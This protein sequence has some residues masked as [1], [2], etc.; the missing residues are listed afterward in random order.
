MK[1]LQEARNQHATRYDGDGV[2]LDTMWH[3]VAVPLLE[4][5]HQRDLDCLGHS[6]SLGDAR[7]YLAGVLEAFAQELPPLYQEVQNMRGPG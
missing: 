4:N 5:V 2:A 3:P 6:H 7:G 1:D